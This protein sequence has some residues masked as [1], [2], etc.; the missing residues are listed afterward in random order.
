MLVLPET[1]ND[2]PMQVRSHIS[3]TGEIDL[4]GTHRLAYRC[5]HC[6]HGR[7]EMFTL[8]SG[9]VG[10]LLDVPIPDH[11]AEA[12]VVRILDQHDAATGILPDLRAANLVTQLACRFVFH[13]SSFI[14]C[15]AF[16]TTP[17]R[18]RRCLPWQH[19]PATSSC[20]AD[21]WPFRPRCNLR[22]CRYHRCSATIPAGRTGKK[23]GSS[24]RR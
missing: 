24:L 2:M 1:R 19:S 16:I 23:S 11:T 12:G 18:F 14:P 9:K 3:E 5:F 4:V 20:R 22:L 7:H 10:H 21:V 17:V 13:E 15:M 6:K 8:G